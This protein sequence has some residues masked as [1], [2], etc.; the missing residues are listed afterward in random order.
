MKRKKPLQSTVQL[1]NPYLITF[2]SCH[3]RIPYMANYIQQ[4]EHHLKSFISDFSSICCICSYLRKVL[5]NW[6]YLFSWK[7][8]LMQCIVVQLKYVL[9]FLSR[10]SD[11]CL[12]SI[13]LVLLLSDSQVALSL[14]FSYC[15]WF[16]TF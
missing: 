6:Q 15:L 16:S 8:Y 4:T 13:E 5:K 2:S 10:Y 1:T 14:L 3:T 7:I 12:E 9:I 11:I